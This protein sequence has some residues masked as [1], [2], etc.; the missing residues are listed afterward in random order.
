MA[1][2]EQ[3]LEL[4]VEEKGGKGKLIIIIA[5]AVVL[6]G[7]GIAAWLF[8]GGDDEPVQEEVSEEQQQEPEKGPAI[9]V[10]VPEAIISPLSGNSRNR[11][12]Q[13]KVSFVVRSPESEDVVKKHMPRLKNDLLTLVS[14]ANADEI[15]TPEGRQ[16]LQQD[17]LKTAQQT[18]VTLEGAEHIEKVL[19]VSFVMQ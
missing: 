18:M 11:M 9:Y 15:I 13:I 4:D 3:E 12:V 1:E 17:C 2:E 10:G 5:A 7:G 16:K 19:F 14:G 8:L 6:I